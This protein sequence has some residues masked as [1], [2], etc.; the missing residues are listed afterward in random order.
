MGCEYIKLFS[1]EEEEKMEARPLPKI[2]TG[3]LLKVISLNVLPPAID[4]AEN[5]MREG[6]V[7]LDIGMHIELF[8]TACSN[9]D[10][11]SQG[12]DISSV[13]LT[14]SPTNLLPHKEE[15]T[16]LKDLIHPSGDHLT[17]MN[18]FRRFQTKKNKMQWYIDVHLDIDILREA[19]HNKERI[20]DN[21]LRARFNTADL[22]RQDEDRSDAV[23]SALC[24]GYFH[25]VGMARSPGVIDHSFTWLMDTQ[26][27]EEQHQPLEELG[28]ECSCGKSSIESRPT[29]ARR[30]P[31]LWFVEPDVN[32][33]LFSSGIITDKP[34]NRTIKINLV[35]KVTPSQLERGASEWCKMSDFKTMYDAHKRMTHK[36]P[37]TSAERPHFLLNR[38]AVI[39]KLTRRYEGSIISIKDDHIVMSCPSAMSPILQ[40]KIEREKGQ[41]EEEFVMNIPDQVNMGEFFGKQGNTTAELNWL[42][43]SGHRINGIRTELSEFAE[44]STGEKNN[45]LIKGPSDKKRQI[46]VVIRGRAKTIASILLSRIQSYIESFCSNQLAVTQITGTNTTTGQH[47]RERLA[48]LSNNKPP[49]DWN[50]RDEGMLLIAHIIIWQTDSSIYGGFLRDW[51]VSGRSAVDIEVHVGGQ[52]D[53]I[54]QKIVDSLRHTNIRLLQETKPTAYL[55]NVK[56]GNKSWDVTVDLVQPHLI[57]NQNKPYVDSDVGNMEFNKTQFLHKKVH[58]AGG[59]DYPIQKCMSHAQKKFVFLY[60]LKDDVNTSTPAIVPKY[61]HLMKPKEKYRREWWNM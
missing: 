50:T 10:C 12:V 8:L 32:L 1:K 53:V 35:T 22:N 25:R 4:D 13:L 40:A 20:L 3:N 44:Q 18:V 46:Q 27:R 30:G 51:I 29:E 43:I 33:I 37:L 28:I 45:L 52:P 42:T 26:R 9:M 49:T 14:D 39:K 48:C 56:F 15:K 24:A 16:S 41:A 21:L 58:E 47:L 59:K 36:I 19:K 60:N 54:K 61:Q 7:M 5:I 2:H 38:G 31:S 11:L 17:L 23:I 34:H 57:K 6:R 55:V